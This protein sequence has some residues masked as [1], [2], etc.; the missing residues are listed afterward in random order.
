MRCDEEKSVEWFSGK[1]FCRII[2]LLRPLEQSQLYI[3]YETPAL[4]FTKPEFFPERFLQ[5]V[6]QTAVIFTYGNTPLIFVMK[7]QSADL[8]AS[9]EVWTRHHV[10]RDVTLNHCVNGSGS[11]E[12]GYSSRKGG[13]P[14]ASDAG[15]HPR[16][17]DTSRCSVYSQVKVK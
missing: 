17:S 1:C 6:T 5:F 2:S 10:F 8:W 14:T 15:S 3:L 13:N 9:A 4:I 12:T 11:V 7:T 16:K